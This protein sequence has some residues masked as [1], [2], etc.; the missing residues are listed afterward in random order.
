MRFLPG[1]LLALL[2]AEPLAGCGKVPDVADPH[3]GV[4]EASPSA[5]ASGSPRA[6]P[7]PGGAAAPEAPGSPADPS[8]PVGFETQV[9]PLLQERCSPCHFPG[10]TMHDRLPFDDEPTVR[11]LGEALFTRIRDAEGRALLET[12]LGTPP[13]GGR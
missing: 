3:D 8:S 11:R 6:D 13:A 12:F 10:G 7:R 1:L 2:M 4:R 5:P 9:R